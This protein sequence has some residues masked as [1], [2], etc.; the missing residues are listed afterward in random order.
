MFIAVE[1]KVQKNFDTANLKEKGM[2]HRKRLYTPQTISYTYLS[3][4]ICTIKWQT[5][6]DRKLY[7]V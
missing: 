1:E 4:E 7:Y 3:E 2:Q 6:S 5:L